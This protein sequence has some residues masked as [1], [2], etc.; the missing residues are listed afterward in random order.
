[1]NRRDP[2]DDEMSTA[3]SVLIIVVIFALVIL[4]SHI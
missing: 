3:L 1:M 2:H 4:A